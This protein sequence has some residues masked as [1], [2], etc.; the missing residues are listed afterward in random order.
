MKKKLLLIPILLI[1]P[2]MIGCKYDTP[3]VG[4]REWVKHNGYMNHEP[5]FSVQNKEEERSG[6]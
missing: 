2:M 4:V 6:A 1:G 5:G 3:L